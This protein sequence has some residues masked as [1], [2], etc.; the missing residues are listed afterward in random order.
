MSPAFTA[1]PCTCCQR[2]ELNSVNVQL[3]LAPNPPQ[4]KVWLISA[5]F[6]AFS[7]EKPSLL[8]VLP[9]P[10]RTEG[11]HSCSLG[12]SHWAPAGVRSAL[13]QVMSELGGAPWRWCGPASPA[14]L[15]LGTMRAPRWVSPLLYLQ[16]D[17]PKGMIGTSGLFCCGLGSWPQV[18]W[19]LFIAILFLKAKFKVDEV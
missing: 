1:I 14:V 10:T 11:S 18:Y 16:Q 5:G 6:A 3:F 7:R 4:V 13:G 8:N 19:V 17:T 2:A 12:F 15:T 9:V